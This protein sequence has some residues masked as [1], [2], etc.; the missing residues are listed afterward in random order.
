VSLP[1]GTVRQLEPQTLGLQLG[2]SLRDVLVW[3][4]DDPTALTIVPR[5]EAS[6]ALVLIIKAARG[7]DVGRLI[8]RRGTVVDGLRS[9]VAAVGLR[10]GLRCR[11]EV[12]E[13]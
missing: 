12:S 8:D 13:T 1:S 5:W 7:A 2:A 3:L 10:H 9:V 11:V 6:D 4:V